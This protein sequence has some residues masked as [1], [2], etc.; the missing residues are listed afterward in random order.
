MFIT[1]LHNRNKKVVP[2][3][4]EFLIQI[5]LSTKYKFNDI[6]NYL[7]EEYFARQIFWIEKN[8]KISSLSHIITKDLPEIFQAV[9]VSN[10]L[11]EFP[12]L[13]QEFVGFQIIAQ[14]GMMMKKQGIIC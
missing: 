3:I 4:G 6:K 2:D 12:N 14:Y 10:H 11:R 9:K 8:S 1:A 5:A 7:Y 13:V